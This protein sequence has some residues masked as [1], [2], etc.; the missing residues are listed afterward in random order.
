V[1]QMNGADHGIGTQLLQTE[2]AAWTIVSFGLGGRPTLPGPRLQSGYDGSMVYTAQ[3]LKK[4]RVTQSF[5]YNS[6]QDRSDL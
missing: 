5:R 1:S 3:K 4:I 2:G 6:L